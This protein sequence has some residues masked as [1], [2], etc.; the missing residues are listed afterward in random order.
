MRNFKK[1]SADRSNESNRIDRSRNE[2]STFHGGFA[3]RI[4][5]NESERDRDPK[6]KREIE[7]R[8]SSERESER[9]KEDESVGQRGNLNLDE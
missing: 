2:Y 5:R 6:R 9:R 7:R 8:E 4:Q 3:L 1:K